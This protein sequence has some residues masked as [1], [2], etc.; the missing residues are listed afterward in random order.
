MAKFIMRKPVVKPATGLG[1]P[2]SGG[3]HF[4]PLSWGGQAAPL[5]PAFQ[6][7]LAAPLAVGLWQAMGSVW[8]ASC[9]GW[10]LV[11]R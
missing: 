7:S 9:E 8:S 1:L 6:T 10:A 4:C 11:P 5:L 3:G 2:L